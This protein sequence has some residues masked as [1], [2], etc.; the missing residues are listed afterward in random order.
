MRC[1]AGWMKAWAV[2]GWVVVWG[3]SARAQT[4]SLLVNGSF[5]VPA[6]EGESTQGGEPRG[7]FFF[8]PK[9]AS[10]AA[11]TSVAWQEGVQALVLELSPEKGAF[12]GVG[13]RFAASPEARYTYIAHV[14]SDRTNGLAGDASGYIGMEWYD[15]KGKGIRKDRGRR[16]GFQLSS[17]RWEQVVL[18]AV[19]PPGAAEGVVTVICESAAGGPCVCYVDNVQLLKSASEGK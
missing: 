12:A 8:S 18:T 10:R 2:M 14:R 7:W 17:L 19:S 1:G 3:G 6:V 16:W 9:P 4:E 15:R 11:V 5:E 13:Q